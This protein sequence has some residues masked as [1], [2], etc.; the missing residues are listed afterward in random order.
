M[1]CVCLCSYTDDLV[2]RL[3]SLSSSPILAVRGLSSQ[4][5]ARLI[6]QCDTLSCINGIISS[7]PQSNVSGVCYNQLHGQLLQLHCLLKYLLL[8]EV[9]KYVLCANIMHNT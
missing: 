6:L 5:M 2:S 7:L 4:A 3:I 8:S 1:L 9:E